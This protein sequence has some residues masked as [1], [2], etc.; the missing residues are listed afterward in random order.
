[1]SGA[2]G[3]EATTATLIKANSTSFMLKPPAFGFRQV[4]S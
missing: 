3:R 2:G 4:A 1:M